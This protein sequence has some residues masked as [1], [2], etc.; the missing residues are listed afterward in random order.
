MAALHVN[1]FLNPPINAEHKTGQAAMTVV[2]VYGR[3]AHLRLMGQIDQHKF[4]AGCKTLFGG[5]LKEILK[6]QLLYLKL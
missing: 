1:H 6:Q 2:W 3:P 5:S 4:A